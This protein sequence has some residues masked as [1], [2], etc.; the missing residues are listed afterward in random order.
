MLGHLRLQQLLQD[1]LYNFAQEAR[2]VQQ[3]LLRELHIRLT[4]LIGHRRSLPI[5]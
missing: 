4:M 3:D 2:G 5:D 1:P